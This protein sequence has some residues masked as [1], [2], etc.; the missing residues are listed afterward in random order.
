MRSLI[1]DRPRQPIAL[2]PARWTQ[3]I[4]AARS[5]DEV[6][7]VAREFVSK[8][9]AHEIILLPDSCRALGF[10]DGRGIRRLADILLDEQMSC[11]GMVEGLLIDRAAV[12]FSAAAFRL[13]QLDIAA[14]G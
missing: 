4:G 14:K 11:D 12:F 2:V 9:S 7:R 5:E 3:A 10:V 6:L 8:W 13:A 1:T